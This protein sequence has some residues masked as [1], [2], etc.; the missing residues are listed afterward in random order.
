MNSVTSL[1]FEG[2]TFSAGG[3]YDGAALRVWL[4]GDANINAAEPVAR[5]LMSVHNEAK[6]LKVGAVIV[7]FSKLEFINSACLK[8]FVT[9]ISHV[10]DLEPLSQ[11]QIRLVQ[12]QGA[13]A[14]AEHERASLCGGSFG[15]PRLVGLAKS[16]APLGDAGFDFDDV[17][18][19]APKRFQAA[20]LPVQVR[21][22]QKSH[23]VLLCRNRAELRRPA[24]WRSILERMTSGSRAP[25]CRTSC[26][27]RRG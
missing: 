21:I 2:N 1:T 6:R 11:Y 25:E 19:D 12:R 27:S 4:S 22:G 16:R 8:R 23:P 15:H 26:A 3:S 10:R 9:W 24:S 17:L 7:D 14:E 5:L 13:M 20:P 18:G